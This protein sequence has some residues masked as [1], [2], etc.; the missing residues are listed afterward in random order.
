[1]PDA[2]LTFQC[3]HIQVILHIVNHLNHFPLAAGAARL[4][5]L[6]NEN[7]DNPYCTEEQ[8]LTGAV[9]SSPNAQ[10]SHRSFEG[11][12]FMKTIVKIRRFNPL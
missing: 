1:M 2:L 4:T 5:S 12:N 3:L 6:V 8:E 9:F 7:Q 10:V 11:R